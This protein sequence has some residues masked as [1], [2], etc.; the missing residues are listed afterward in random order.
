VSGGLSLPRSARSN[1]CSSCAAPTSGYALSTTLAVTAAGLLVRERAGN[2]GPGF[3]CGYHGWS[4]ALDGTLVGVPQA[5][6]FGDI[7]RSCLGLKPVRCE[8]WGTFLFVNLDPGAEPLR[9]ALGV[10][11][12]DL[13]SQIGD[14]ADVGPVRLVGRRSIDVDGN[15]KLTVDA[16]SRP[17]M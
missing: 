3:V 9:D 5:K 13:G 11:G 16:M 10:V 15:W 2:T 6:D 7:D 17:T 14:G 4:Y 8:A 1:P 12:E